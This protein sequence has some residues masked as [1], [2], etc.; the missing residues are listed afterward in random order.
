MIRSLIAL[1]LA[2]VDG[3]VCLALGLPVAVSVVVPCAAFAIATV[4]LSVVSSS[5]H[6]DRAQRGTAVGEAEPEVFR[7]TSR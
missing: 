7:T 2:A 5:E 4:A 6:H 3:G 1:G